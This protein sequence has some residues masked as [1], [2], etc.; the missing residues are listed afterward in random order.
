MNLWMPSSSASERGGASSLLRYRRAS[1]ALYV[2]EASAPRL[3]TDG[4]LVR[5]RDRCDL[6]ELR[7][8]AR[9]PET[10]C[11]LVMDDLPC[12]DRGP[13]GTLCHRRG[14]EDYPEHGEHPLNRQARLDMNGRPIDHRWQL[15]KV[16]AVGEF[17]RWRD[18]RA[19]VAAE[20]A[21]RATASRPVVPSREASV[22]LHPSHPSEAASECANG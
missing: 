15:P 1:G 18:D 16:D 4:S 13:V 12:L 19:F 7:Q 21:C 11:G 17:A 2:R 5:I 22:P 14:M 10:P 3:R 8:S 20:K 6:G 9:P